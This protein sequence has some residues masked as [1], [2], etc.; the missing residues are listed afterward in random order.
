METDVTPDNKR[1][2]RIED[3]AVDRVM[4]GD[5]SSAQVYYDPM[6]PNSFG[7]NSTE[8][9]ALPCC[10]DDALVDK[11]AETPKT[12]LSPV[13]ARTQTATGSLLPAGTAP[14]SFVGRF[15]FGRCDGI[16]GWSVLLVVGGLEHYFREKTSDSLCRTYCYG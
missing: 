2:K 7:D 4:S 15:S 11:G 14:R 10:R 3:A 6:C 9:P 13:E 5:N 1:R 12:G 16:R 8:P